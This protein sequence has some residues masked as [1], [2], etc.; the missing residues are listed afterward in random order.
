MS[1]RHCPP[2]LLLCGLLAGCAASGT[3]PSLAPRPEELGQSSSPA[4]PKSIPAPA[5]P[6]LA[7]QISR[8]L[9]VAREGDAK[10]KAAVPATERAI[11]SAGK[12]GSD[13]WVEAQQALSRLET[14]RTQ[15]T[16]SGAD[17]NTLLRSKME[18]ST[19]AAPADI[20]ALNA[21]I[22]QVRALSDVQDQVI[23]RLSSAL[24][25]A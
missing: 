2:I 15:T 25:A 12:T 16:V 3:F 8:L 9:G 24:P 20:D 19:P 22:E 5:D 21:A 23:E 18:A 14:D 11:R 4:P 10:F 17:L 13:S 6:A 1:M 7:G